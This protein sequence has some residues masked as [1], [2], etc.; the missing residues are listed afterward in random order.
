[1]V[2]WR[3][4]IDLLGHR[5]TI[6]LLFVVNFL[7][8]IYGYIW[9]KNQLAETVWWLW[10]FVPDSPTASLFFTIVLFAFILRKHW[11]LIEAFAAVTLFKYGIWAS[12]MIIWTG[13]L[14]GEL[15]WQHY[16]L[17]FSHLG[18]ALQ[19]LLYSPYLSFRF[20]HLFIVSIWTLTNDVLDYS[21]AIFP[22]LDQRLYPYLS[23]VYVFTLGLS[24][25]SILI[26]FF[27]VVYKNQ[28]HNADFRQ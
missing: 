5:S 22:W 11:P 17:L 15:Y 8:T 9:Y 6:W 21:I 24:L 2:Y 16:M 4:F 10:P 1:L 19:A 3:W 13:A 14:G 23:T 25:V 18:M 20:K 27:S 7:G 28:F 12:V 26:F